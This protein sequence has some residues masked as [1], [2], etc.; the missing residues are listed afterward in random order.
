MCEEE[1]RFLH[2]FRKVLRS[3]YSVAVLYLE[4][5]IWQ[6]ADK[7]PWLLEPSTSVEG[8]GRRVHRT[9]NKIC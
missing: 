6:K 4:T 8:W 5:G 3:T 9:T 2:P 1:M 7:V